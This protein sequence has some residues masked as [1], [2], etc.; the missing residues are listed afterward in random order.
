MAGSKQPKQMKVTQEMRE[1]VRLMKEQED[2]AEPSVD[3]S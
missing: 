1:F 2:S 3:D